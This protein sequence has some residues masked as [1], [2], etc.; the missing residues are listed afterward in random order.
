MSRSDLLPL[1]EYGRARMLMQGGR[2]R[3]P[4][5]RLRVL[6][7]FATEDEAVSYLRDTCAG[8]SVSMGGSMTMKQLGFPENFAD[9]T[10]VHWHWISKGVYCQTPDV[11]L[12]FSERD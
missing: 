2:R 7:Y 8:K 12:S 4:R 1:F 9:S 11:Y 6:H 10:D 3:S 5:L